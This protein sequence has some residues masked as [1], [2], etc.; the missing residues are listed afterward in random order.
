MNFRWIAIPGQSICQSLKFNTSYSTGQYMGKNFFCLKWL[1]KKSCFIMVFKNRTLWQ[2][3]YTGEFEG[4]GAGE[5]MS[6]INFVLL[7]NVLMTPYC[8]LMGVPSKYSSG[9]LT[10]RTCANLWKR[11]TWLSLGHIFKLVEQVYTETYLY[12]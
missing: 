8:T 9:P 10:M 1:G 5:P 6:K 11:S 4:R 7:K 12:K 3:R 2:R